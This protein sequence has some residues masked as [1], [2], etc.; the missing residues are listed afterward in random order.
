M[1]LPAA[2]GG[3][4]V[5]YYI[6]HRVEEG[7]G[8]N[9]EALR[10]LAREHRRADRHGRLRDLGGA[11]AEL[12]RELGVELIITDHHTIGSSCRRPT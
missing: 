12:A 1:G 8:V 2:R 7:Y 10:R 5:E 3:R 9:A 4:D 6:P 11:E